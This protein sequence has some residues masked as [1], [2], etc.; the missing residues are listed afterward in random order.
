MRSS[1]KHLI[2]CL[3][4]LCLTSCR[5]PWHM[6]DPNLIYH[7]FRDI[8]PQGWNQ[9]DTLVFELPQADADE[10]LALQVQVRVARTYPYTNLQLRT[11]IEET[12]N[13]ATSL[14]CS[15]R[16]DFDLSAPPGSHPRQGLTFADDSRPIGSIHIQKG[17]RCRLLVTH[18]M[19]RQPLTGI[20]GIGVK[21]TRCHGAENDTKNKVS[22]IFSTK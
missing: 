22:G 18:N 16:V 19:R 13:H 4:L 1:N 10:W 6:S 12:Q 7:Q 11:W 9:T 2:L 15:R 3:C 5:R 17:H 21:A 8:G 14:V 20:A